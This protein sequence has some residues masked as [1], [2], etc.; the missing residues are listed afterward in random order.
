MKLALLDHFLE[1]LPPPHL[2]ND[3]LAL[4]ETLALCISDA[5]WTISEASDRARRHQR[6]SFVLD[7]VSIDQGQSPLVFQL[8]G[9]Q[10]TSENAC[11]R[12]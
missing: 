3:V 7:N 12:S 2:A 5:E 8:H 11:F 6:D 1:L 4:T 10:R 9:W